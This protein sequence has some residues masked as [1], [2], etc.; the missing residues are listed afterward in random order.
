[1]SRQVLHRIDPSRN[2]ARFYQ[3]EAVTD[4]F[5]EI[6]LERSWGRIATQGQSRL[7]SF[8][9]NVLAEEAA[10]KILSTKM[11]RGYVTIDFNGNLSRPRRCC[12]IG[13]IVV[14][15]EFG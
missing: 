6:I 7:V 12:P 15:L 4:L 1:M 8:A 2:M 14:S 13:Q 9:T 3:V 11:R 10:S 5:G